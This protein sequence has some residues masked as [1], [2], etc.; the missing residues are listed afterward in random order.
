[1]FVVVTLIQNLCYDFVLK[2]E[3]FCWWDMQPPSTRAPVNLWV[4]LHL[5]A[6]R[7]EA[8]FKKSPTAAL[9]RWNWAKTT[10]GVWKTLP[11]PRLRT[12]ATSGLT[13]EWCRANNLNDNNQIAGINYYNH[14]PQPIPNWMNRVMDEARRPL[15]SKL[16]FPLTLLVK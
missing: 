10:S 1:M 16:L 7:W 9:C 6:K 8:S 13:G 5:L 3:M 12:R 11:S 14:V 15:H 4:V 2:V